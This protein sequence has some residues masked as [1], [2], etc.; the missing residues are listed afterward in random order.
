[1]TRSPDTGLELAY[2]GIE[3][4]DPDAVGSL[5]GDIIGLVPGDPTPFG[6]ATWRNDDKAQRVIITRGPSNDAR[7]VGFETDDR[8]FATLVD[9][10]RAGG[11]DVE[12]ADRALLQERRVEQLASI[13]SPWGCRFELVVGLAAGK[14]FRSPLA[15]HGFRT[16]G[17][18]F[19]HVVFQLGD[20][21]AFAEAHMFA[22][23][24]L[25][26]RQSDWFE[27]QIGPVPATANFYHCNSRHHT[28]AL[29]FSPAFA[30]PHA[31]EHIMF[32][33]EEEE[34]MGAAYDRAL[35]AR[36]PIASSLGRHDNDRMLSFY[37]ASPAG[38]RLE[39][40]HGAR[41]ITEPWTENR[42]YEKPSVWGH[43]PVPG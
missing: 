6:A 22:T 28:L 16:S 17:V 14:A 37:L 34:E 19:G 31:L 5:L 35:S 15:P 23:D 2:V 36:V 1:M 42:R 39:V 11:T 30:P 3:V 26:L 18:G 32:E 7:F 27:G 43:M 38:F 24:I 40:G 12:L 13:V 10:L 25:G 4:D 9:R 20:E 41:E 29:G 33:M 21:K 8:G